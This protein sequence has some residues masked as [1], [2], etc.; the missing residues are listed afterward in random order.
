MYKVTWDPEGFTSTLPAI[1]TTLLGIFTGDWLRS[2]RDRQTIALRMFAM[3][4]VAVVV[5]L[6]WSLVFP[7]NKNLWTSS[8]VV[9]T[10][11]AA[12]V[13]LAICYWLIDI[14][15]YRDWAK[16]FVV[17]GVNAIAA[18]VLSGLI[19]RILLF[20]QV[21]VGDE[22]IPAK[23]WIFDQWFAPLAAPLDASL[24]YA[25]TQLLAVWLVMALLYK[26]RIFIKV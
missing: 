15:G 11:G 6:A 25:F 9:F 2:S 20:A 3:G 26:R 21:S 17:F 4:W 8:Y 13:S 24:L 1:A 22:S 5:G 12:W 23:K 7:I 18:F 16:P 10:A 19:T 14:K